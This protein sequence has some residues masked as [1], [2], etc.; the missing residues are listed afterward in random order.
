MKQ[1]TTT[2]QHS[3]EHKDPGR[4]AQGDAVT[5][6]RPL[7]V[8]RGRFQPSDLGG[9]ETPS[10][11]S[12][13]FFF[14]MCVFCF[15]FLIPLFQVNAFVF[16]FKWKGSKEPCS[17]S[18]AGEPRGWQRAAAAWLALWGNAFPHWGFPRSDPTSG[19]AAAHGRIWVRVLPMVCRRHLCCTPLPYPPWT[20]S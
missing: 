10:I 3:T 12:E 8:R 6:A 13:F 18:P 20:F 15:L 4:R 16:A 5:A 2:Q 11:T 19:T 9:I 17:C 14:C 1:H 7:A